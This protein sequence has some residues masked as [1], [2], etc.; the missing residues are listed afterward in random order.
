[1]AKGTKYISKVHDEQGF[2]AWSAEENS[3][4]QELFARQLACIKD[5]ACD[6]YHDG[7]AKLNLPT[8]RIPQLDDVSQV[9]NAT[10]G[11]Q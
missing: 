6:E 10:T 4:W 5:K 3:I 7:L 1:M 8:D 9:L 11:W 2:I